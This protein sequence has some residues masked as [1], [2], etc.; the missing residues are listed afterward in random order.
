MFN[1]KKFI[2]DNFQG[3]G[4]VIAHCRSVGWAPPSGG[5]VEK[6]LERNSVPGEWLAKLLSLLEA[7]HG[8]P[9]SIQP[10]IGAPQ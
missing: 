9:V 2:R 7:Q 5:Q 6:W 10:Y 3:P 1:A 4:G 8:A